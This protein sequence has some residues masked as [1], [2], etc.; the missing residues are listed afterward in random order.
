MR[1]TNAQVINIINGVNNS[2]DLVENEF[3]IKFAWLFQKNIKILNELADMINQQ[4]ITLESKYADDEHSVNEEMV[5]DNGKTQI[6]R[7][8]K[9]EYVQ[10]FMKQRMEFLNLD[11]DINIQTFKVEDLGDINISLAVMNTLSFM[12]EE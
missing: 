4:L 2:K 6:K 8:V 12:L 5:D 9:P 11:N 3:P 10:Q 7:V 1:L